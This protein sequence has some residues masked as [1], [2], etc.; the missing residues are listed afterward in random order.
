MEKSAKIYVS[1]RFVAA[2]RRPSEVPHIA[3]DVFESALAMRL[4][5][6]PLA[7]VAGSI[8]PHLSHQNHY[9]H[10]MLMMMIVIILYIYHES[11]LCIHVV[12]LLIIE[13]DDVY[14]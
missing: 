3:I 2:N 11:I 7:A 14:M 4:V 8:G 9:T 12:A 13:Y 5:P 1:K 10:S 6:H